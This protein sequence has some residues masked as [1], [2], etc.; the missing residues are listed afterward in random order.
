MCYGPLSFLRRIIVTPHE[1]RIP[2]RSLFLTR[3]E[4]EKG[5]F[6]ARRNP[7]NLTALAKVINV[8]RIPVINQTPRLFQDTQSLVPKYIVRPISLSI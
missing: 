8:K 2:A 3:L 6:M 7:V 4:D 5:K 1:V